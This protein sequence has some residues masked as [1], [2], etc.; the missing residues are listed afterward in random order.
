VTTSSRFYNRC[1]F[2]AGYHQAHHLKPQVP[3][4]ALPALTEELV[5]EG[6]V[7]SL[8]W[9]EHAPIHPA[10]IARV[11]AFRRTTGSHEAQAPVPAPAT[12]TSTPPS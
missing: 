5:R 8:L 1:F 2:N 7:P 6:Q 12:D 9:T 10:W 3:W 11:S 4:R